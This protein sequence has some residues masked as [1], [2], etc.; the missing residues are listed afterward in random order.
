MT[1]YFLQHFW[2]Q[3]FLDGAGRVSMARGVR[4]FFGY[5]ETVE[6]RVKIALAEIL[7]NL[8]AAVTRDQQLAC[9]ARSE[10]LKILP[11]FR[12]DG[13]DTVAACVCLFSADHISLVIISDRKVK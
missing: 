13:N 3:P 11:T 8:L 5:I 4:R 6:Q 1:E 12:A 9:C 10:I 7:N 2:G